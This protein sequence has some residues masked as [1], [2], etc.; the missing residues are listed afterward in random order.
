MWSNLSIT[1]KGLSNQLMTYYKAL[2]IL[3]NSFNQIYVLLDFSQWMINNKFPKNDVITQF[4]S[5]IELLLNV[6]YPEENDVSDEKSV[7]SKS[8]KKSRNSKTSRTSRTSRVSRT[9]RTSRVSMSRPSLMRSRVSK[10]ASSFGDAETSYVS[11]D[12]SIIY[13][14]FRKR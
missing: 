2:Q 14:I 10:S 12:D 5:I 11:S 7:Q 4:R 13:L 1:A 3:Q 9:S 6:E 8:S